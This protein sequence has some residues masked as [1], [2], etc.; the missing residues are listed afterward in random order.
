FGDALYEIAA[1][2]LKRLRERQNEEEQRLALQEAAQA[3]IEEVKAEAA[4]VVAHVA[5]DQPPQVQQALTAYLVQVPAAVRQSL[6]RPAD[7]TGTTVPLGFCLQRPE[8]LVPLLPARVPRFR[9][10]DRPTPGGNW[11]LVDLLGVGGFGEVW[12]A[13][14]PKFK[15]IAPVA[16]KFC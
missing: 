16:L 14:H 1:E 4:A 15:G 11:E 2:A 6:K 3:A 7:P 13:R 8:Q 5:G 9:P 10:G 12:L